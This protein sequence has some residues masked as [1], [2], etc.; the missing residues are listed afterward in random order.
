[1]PFELFCI[2]DYCT[3]PLRGMSKKAFYGCNY[4][5]HKFTPP[6]MQVV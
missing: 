3:T 4:S 1:M 2:L 5:L 6:I